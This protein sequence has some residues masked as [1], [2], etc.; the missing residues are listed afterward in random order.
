MAG[1][2]SVWNVVVIGAWNTAILSPDGIRR[3]LFRLAEGVPVDLQMAIDR[4]GLFQVRHDGVVVIPTHSRLEAVAAEGTAG[5]LA[6]AAEICQRA[7]DELPS[8]PMTAAGVNIRYE[9]EEF[10]DDLLAR[11]RAPLDDALANA[12]CQ[13][14]ASS[15]RRTVEIEQGVVNMTVTH[16]PDGNGTLEF[17]F[18]RDSQD[19]EELKAWLGETEGFVARA[20]TLAEVLGVT[21]VE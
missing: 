7:I 17:N 12:E 8:T 15:I 14:R 6:R 18:H 16:S 9:F 1:D 11:V 10:A 3:R 5:G 21:D 20:G 2:A 4:P 19:P 13:I